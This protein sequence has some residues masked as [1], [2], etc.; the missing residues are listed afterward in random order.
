M[1]APAAALI[2]PQGLVILRYAPGFTA[3]DVHDDFRR[4]IK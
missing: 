1:S 3:R 4:L 2:H